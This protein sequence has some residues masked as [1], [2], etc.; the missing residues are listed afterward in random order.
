[1]DPQTRRQAEQQGPEAQPQ[2]YAEG[3]QRPRDI[4]ATFTYFS[5][6]AALATIIHPGLV[7]VVI[8]PV[9]GV[10]LAYH[11]VFSSD[12]PFWVKTHY[13]YQVVTF[14]L[15]VVGAGIAL[16]IYPASSGFGYLVHALVLAWVLMRSIY[17]LGQL[18]RRDAIAEPGSFFFGW[19][20]QR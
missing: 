5:F 2:G 18:S 16:L 10:G 7:I 4:R 8:L 3:A 9:I 11:G 12:A 1:M 20:R 19:K 14:W 6:L 15:A 17:G 13:Q